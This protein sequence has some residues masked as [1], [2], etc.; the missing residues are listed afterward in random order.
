MIGA[1]GRILAV[2]IVALFTACGEAAPPRPEI[3]VEDAW[4]RAVAGPDAN[5]AAYMTLR[6]TGGAPDRLIGARSAVS[7]MTE[8]HRTTIDEA[9]LARMGKVEALDLPAGGA[10]VLEP[11]GYHLMLMGAGPL[12]EGD[13]VHLIL[14]LDV[15][16]SVYVAAEVRP[17]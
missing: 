3:G 10:A 6:N 5:T 1:R 11:G 8:L 9:G 7:R 16:D 15:S 4:I 14:L 2:V 13:T 17:F 12:V